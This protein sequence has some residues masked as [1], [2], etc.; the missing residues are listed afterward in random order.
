MKK[1]MQRRS[2]DKY[3]KELGKTCNTG[4]MTTIVAAVVTPR[5]TGQNVN[6]SDFIVL[7]A[8]AFVFWILGFI[9]LSEKE[10]KPKGDGKWKRIRVKKDTT[11][12][13]MEE[14]TE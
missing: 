7:I 6:P 14:T 10:Q 8:I 9:L 13:I 4:A 3:K 12:H 2:F 1:K 5:V 11:I